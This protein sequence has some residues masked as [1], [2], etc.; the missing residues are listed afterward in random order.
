MLGID[1]LLS[2]YDKN[3]FFEEIWQKRP[4]VLATGRAGYFE[5]V[6]SKEEVERIIDSPTMVV[7]PVCLGVLQ[8]AGQSALLAQWSNRHRPSEEIILS[9]SIRDSGGG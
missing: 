7:N 4:E 9:G 1:W 3:V 6:F 8:R 2:P 5:G